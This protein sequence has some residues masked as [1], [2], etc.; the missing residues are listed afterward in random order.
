M[1]A[2]GEYHLPRDLARHLPERGPFQP[3]ELRDVCW[4]AG[5]GLGKESASRGEFYQAAGMISLWRGLD[6]PAWEAPYALRDA[7]LGYLSGFSEVL[8]SGNLDETTASRAAS[9]RWGNRGPERLQAL[10]ERQGRG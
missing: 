9:A 1:S 4:R 2:A 5:E 10:R 7:R 8:V 3:G 6:L